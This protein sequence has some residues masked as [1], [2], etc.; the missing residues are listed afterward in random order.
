M[1]G[2][3][4]IPLIIN[5]KFNKNKIFTIGYFGNIDPKYR[6]VEP[7][8]EVLFCF[9]EEIRL[10]FFGMVNIKKEILEKLKKRIQIYGI[11]K[12][13]EAL[14]YMQKMDIL[15]ILHHNL[16]NADEVITGKFFEYVQAQKP[17]LVVGPENMFVAKLVRENKL[18]Y[19]MNIFNKE[20]MLIK[21]NIIYNDWQ[22]NR[23]PKYDKKEFKK[24]SREYQFQKILPILK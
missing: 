24:F 22:K 6:A 2:Y 14:K 15:L 17:I 16:N 5:K 19:A 12:H 10:H 21:L 23:L 1:N 4:D 3:D 20:D 11:I 13:E 8:L 18:G 7:F 9:S